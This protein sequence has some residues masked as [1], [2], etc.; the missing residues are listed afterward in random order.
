M[1]HTA[2]PSG[3]PHL[4]LKNGQ[5][6]RECSTS[7]PSLQ[8]TLR[9]NSH[10]IS[11]QQTYIDS[12]RS[13]RS[14][15]RQTGASALHLVSQSLQAPGEHDPIPQ[16]S[17]TVRAASPRT[18]QINET[19]VLLEMQDRSQSDDTTPDRHRTSLLQL[20]Q[21]WR[22]EIFSWLLGAIGFLANITLISVSNGVLQKDW[23]SDISIT[24]FVAALAQ[25][26][27]S[28]LLVPTASSIA[29]L[30]WNWVFSIRRPA[31]DIE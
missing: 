2:V 31:M 4:N 24:A 20:F 9:H 16:A 14:I 11:T 30:K 23:K 27:Q 13:N 5:V 18:I 28:A 25:V 15:E 7:G 12:E 22:W 6:T 8:E 3:K 10:G 29:Q 1:A 21:I 19:Q 26:S 17:V